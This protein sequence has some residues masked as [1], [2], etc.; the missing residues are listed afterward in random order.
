V[1]LGLSSGGEKGI[2]A[3]GKFI[4]LGWTLGLDMAISLH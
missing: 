4:R 2:A 3:A 1:Q